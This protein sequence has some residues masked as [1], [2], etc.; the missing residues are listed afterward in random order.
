MSDWINEPTNIDDLFGFVYLITDL[1]NDKKYIGK[2][3][4]WKELKKAAKINSFTKAEEEKYNKLLVKDKKLA[5]EFKKQ[6]KEKNR[7][8]KLKVHSRV[9]SDWRIYY[10]SSNEILED[11]KLNGTQNYKREI[12]GV[13]KTKWECA[14][15]E[16]Y[17][18][19]KNEV[20]FCE[21][22]YNGIINIR[23]PK[24]PKELR[25]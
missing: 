1:R 4:F 20:L 15:Y 16:A 7:N 12:I 19:F 2:K 23:L 25:K 3:F 9:E 21:D 13:Y 17:Y 18:Q 14:Y 11:I 22:Y 10:S 5:K 8:K 24:A 6:V